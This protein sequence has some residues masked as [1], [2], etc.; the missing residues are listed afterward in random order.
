MKVGVLGAPRPMPGRLL[1]MCAG[2]LVLAVG[3]AVFLV[4]EWRVA[5][6][7]LGALLWAGSQALGLL[8]ARL[9]ERTSNLAASGVLGFGMM[10]RAVA[11]MVVVIALAASDARLALAAALVYGLAYTAELA[12]S[13][14]SYF[15]SPA[16]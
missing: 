5:G 8:L 12:F 9:G 10:F 13:L 1:P 2:A 14:L 3:L 11:V 16:R 7:L 6:W 4:A 15:G